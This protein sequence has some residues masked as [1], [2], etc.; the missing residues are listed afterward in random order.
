MEAL[1]GLRF[2]HKFTGENSA[3]VG[4][5]ASSSRFKHELLLKPARHKKA[6]KPNAEHLEATLKA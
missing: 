6:A 1:C 2:E 3:L 4:G 5:I